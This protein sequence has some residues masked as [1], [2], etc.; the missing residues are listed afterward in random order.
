MW[1]FRASG[2]IGSITL[3]SIFLFSDATKMQTRCRTETSAGFVG[4]GPLP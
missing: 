4:K 2:L 1:G 3:L